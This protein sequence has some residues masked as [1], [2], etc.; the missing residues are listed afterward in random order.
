[1]KRAEVRHLVIERLHAF[2]DSTRL[3][4]VRLLEQEEL[5]VGELARIVQMPQSTISRHLKVLADLPNGSRRGLLAR[6]AEGTATLYRLVLDDLDRDN[7][8]LWLTIREQVSESATLTEDRRRLAGVLAERRTDTQAYFGRVAGEWDSVRDQLF[9]T[10]FTI[11]ALLC[12]LPASWTVADLGC[13]T[14]NV[15]ELLA[16]VV[17]KV[18]AIDQS[19]PMLTAA[20]QRLVGADNVEFIA[21]DLTALPVAAASVDAAVC[22]LVLHHLPEPAAAIREM[23]RIVKPGGTVLVVDMI[24]HDRPAYKQSMGHRWQGFEAP[25][26]MNMMTAAG[27]DEPRLVVLPAAIEAKGPGL[28]AATANKMVR[29][30]N[31]QMAK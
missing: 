4:L 28:F 24:A 12:L 15:S 22:I 16:P 5:S 23:A 19:E 14:G 8:A 1:M 31:D 30:P 17:H 18:L 6:R 11:Y 29:L 26:M 21:G 7:R 10:D 27:L 2:S 13:G 3:R 9:G 20:R 25:A